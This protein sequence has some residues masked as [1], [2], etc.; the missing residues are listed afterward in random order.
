MAKLY[1][2]YSTMNAGKSTLLLQAAHNYRERGMATLL[3]TA[4]LDGREGHGRI[5][6]R[7]GIGAEALTFDA[8]TDMVGLIESRGRGCACIF[9]DEAQFL[10][11]HQVWQ[12][13]HVADDLR[14]PVMCYGL[15][16][17]FRG[18]LFPGSAALLA[19]ADDL[20][21]VRTIC[22]CGRKATMVIRRGADG[23]ALT[24][25][26]QVQVGGNETYLSLCRR[27]WREATARQRP[28]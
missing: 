23:G 28:A 19:L 11:R 13:A 14:I 3:L 22:H 26:A 24:E 21:E 20:R 27:H 18:E 17:D 2:H 15:R 7:I 6:S 1:F 5:G 8:A 12:L 16:V 9:I 4:A 10:S 25:G